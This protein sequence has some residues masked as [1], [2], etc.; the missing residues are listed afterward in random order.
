MDYL[1]Y[2][3]EKYN[4]KIIQ[5]DAPWLSYDAF[6]ITSSYPA[7]Q[8]LICCCLILCTTLHGSIAYGLLLQK[9]ILTP[10]FDHSSH[11]SA[12]QVS[13]FW[14]YFSST[15]K[16]EKLY[17]AIYRSSAA[18]LHTDQP[19]LQPPNQHHHHHQCSQFGP[20][21]SSHHQLNVKKSQYMCVYI[22]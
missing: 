21:Q 18:L 4:F 20:L 3:N 12:P 15:F 17:S 14:T 19:H 5:K 10:E 6:F 22:F 7:G 11:S 8:Y 13:L 9:N 1:R 2:Y 16:F